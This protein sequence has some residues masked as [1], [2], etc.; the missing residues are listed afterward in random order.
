MKAT[1]YSISPYEK[2]YFDTNGEKGG[3]SFFL[4]KKPLTETSVSLA[5]GSDAVVVFANDLVKAGVL[6]KLHELGIKFIATRSMGMDHIDLEK[7]KELGIKVANVPHYSP[8][9]VAEHSVALMLSLNRRLNLANQKVREHD[10]ELDGLVGFDMHGKTVGLLGAGEIGEVSVKILTGFGCKILI[11]DLEENKELID[12]YQVKYE[13]I[14]EVCK[15][16][17]I[18]SIHAPLTKETKHLIDKEKISWMKK[19]V[20]LINTARGA[21]CKTEALINGLKEGKIGYLGMDVYEHEK[22]LFFENHSN[23]IIQDDLFIRLLGFKNVLIT[24]HQ[25]FLTREAIKE[26][27]E[28]TIQNLKD[29]AAGEKARH[30]QE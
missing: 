9:S 23:D 26:N 4:H 21:I 25:A 16:S 12:K 27:M 8:H 13:S 14:E 2:P 24:A 10:F 30:E 3:I 11:Y 15:K 5:E 29:W 1:V 18:I 17:D 6:E 7:A 22:G 19:G 28:T 20:M